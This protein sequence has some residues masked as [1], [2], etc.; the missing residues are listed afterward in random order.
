MSDIANKI[1][2]GP[3]LLAFLGLVE[4]FRCFDFSF[5]AYIKKNII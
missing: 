5:G 3:Q 1:A 2:W 4:T